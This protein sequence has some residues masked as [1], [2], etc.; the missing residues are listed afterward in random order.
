MTCTEK[1]DA[2]TRKNNSLVCIGLD[3]DPARIP[4][5]LASHPNP[6]LAFNRA[7]IEA[8]ADIAQCYKLN[9][10]FY[11]ALGAA[12]YETIAATLEAIPADIVTI[13]DGKRGDIGN[14]SGMYASALFTTYGFDAVTVAPYMGSDSVSPFL[15]Y[16]E[17]GVFVLALTSNS[18]SRDFQYLPV[19]GEPLYMHVA[20]TILR[21]NSAGN[22]GLV[23]GA[24]HPSE[25]AAIR[26]MAGDVPILVPGLGA[27]GGDME[28]SVK[29]GIDSRGM[30]AIFNSSRAI[31][32][33]GKGE[34]YAAKAREAAATFRNDI[35]ALRGIS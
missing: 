21:W 26:D 35:N 1:L 15:A 18:G 14:T 23:V 34:D 8:T 12:A 20:R 2:I 11:E 6:V 31:L 22:C 27:Q 29:A 19:E 5:C 30:R 28:Q 10:A 17:K 24:T 3:V 7:I 9:L 25:L 16:P 32:Y 33:A 4:S 13:G